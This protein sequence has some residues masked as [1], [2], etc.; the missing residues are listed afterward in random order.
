MA[1][2]STNSSTTSSFSY[3]QYK[4]KIGGLVSGMDIDSLMEKLM[5]A[6]S[7]QME[8]LQQQKQKYE[9]QRDAYRD[10]NLK[11]NT[12]KTDLFDKFGLSSSWTSKTVN[13]NSS[14][15]GVTASS[16]ANGTLN[17]SSATAAT[18]ATSSVGAAVTG[19]LTNQRVNGSTTL[20]N[21]EGFTAPAGTTTLNFSIN[22]EMKSIDVTENTTLDQLKDSLNGLKVTVDGVEKQ[23]LNA[24]IANGKL[25]IASSNGGLEINDATTKNMLSSLGMVNNTTALGNSVKAQNAA[26]ESAAITKDT[27]LASMGLASSGTLTFN[28]GDKVKTISYTAEDDTLGKLF[29]KIN[30][31]STDSNKNDPKLTASVNALGQISITS[32]LGAV[33]LADSDERSKLGFVDKAQTS[34]QL[35]EANTTPS[36]TAKTQGTTLLKELGFGESGTFTLRALQSDGSMKDTEIK[37]NA[38]DTVNALMSRISGAGAGVTAIFN[39]GQMS[40]S[41]SNSGAAADDK[42][43]VSLLSSNAEA[44][45]LFAKLGASSA[46]NADGEIALADGGTNSAVT[47]NGVEYTGTSN[48]FNISGYS[49]Q[50][51][52]D[53]T[54]ADNVSI[55][56]NSDVQGTVD[57]VKEFVNMYNTL[58][59]SLNKQ[60]SEKKNVDYAPL[61]DAQKSEMTTEQISQWEEKAKSGL[62][63]NDNNINTLLSKMRSVLNSGTGTDT[64]YNLGIS[65]SSS[66]TEKGKLEINEDKLKAAIEKDPEALS[67]VFVGTTEKPGMISQLRTAT[68]TAITNIEKTAGKSTS[69]ENQYSLG[70][71]LISIDDKIDNWKTRLKGIEERYWKQFSAMET[72]IQKANSQS[73]I[74][75]AS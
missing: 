22:G 41:A 15:V 73:S 3:L 1:V 70:R 65:T 17:I 44:V 12:F 62:I 31:D 38:T 61:T 74:F 27:T 5:K 26:G 2:N 71:T 19:A 13:S 11:L 42:A 16:T 51:K 23:A 39:N 14:K 29:A 69:V 56:S 53:I 45:N 66:W 43:E 36:S 40:I 64:L 4:N 58:I 9:W 10:V 7:A 37:Y 47:V 63:R 46:A 50:L 67:R 72:A 49:I 8:K 28:V 75:S 32:T 59:E 48:T 21:I 6:E 57:K 35:F 18:A 60:T 30:V 25:S 68:T 34:Q 24:T 54:A 33:T 55:S 20:S 52:G